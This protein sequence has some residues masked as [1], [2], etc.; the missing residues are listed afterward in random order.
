MIRPSK[1][2]GKATGLVSERVAD[3]IL[4]RIASGEW[5]PG[6]RLPGERQLAED[7]GVSRVSV[8]AALQGLKTQG[9][10][11]AVQGGG[12]RVIASKAAMDPGMLELVRVNCENLVDLAEIRSI[13]EVWAV[14]RAALKRDD[15]DLAELEAIMAA[16]EADIVAGKHKSENDVRFHLA[17]AK[18]SRSGI[19]LHFVAMIRGILSEMVDYHR[20]ELFPTPEDDRRILAQHQAIFDGIRARDAAR[21]QDAMRDHLGWV[22]KRYAEQGGRKNS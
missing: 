1:N 15:A 2:S 9:L 5:G 17:V 21:A 20:Y 4:A 18:A 10:L 13:L 19:Y 11:D 14:G 3:R 16:T 12:T 8:R 6:H 22:L 7:M